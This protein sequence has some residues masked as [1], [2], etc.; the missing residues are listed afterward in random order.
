MYF[1]LVLHAGWRDGRGGKDDEHD[2]TP[3]PI[4]FFLIC[5]A[6]VAGTSIV[7]YW[8]LKNRKIHGNRN[9]FGGRRINVRIGDMNKM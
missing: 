7:L 9:S 5:T 6:N 1:W 8:V 2:I 4:N 3:V